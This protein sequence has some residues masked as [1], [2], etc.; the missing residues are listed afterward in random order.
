[1]LALKAFPTSENNRTFCPPGPTRRTSISL[2]QV[3]VRFFSVTVTLVIEGFIPVTL[4]VDGYG[5]PAPE[6][7]IVIGIVLLKV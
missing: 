3:C 7:G 2:T 6:S 1:L 5:D 4:M